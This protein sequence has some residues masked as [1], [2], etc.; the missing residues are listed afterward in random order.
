MS[1][2]MYFKTWLSKNTVIPKEANGCLLYDCCILC[3]II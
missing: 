2:F 1:V 3:R